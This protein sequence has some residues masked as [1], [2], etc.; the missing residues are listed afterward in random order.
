MVR[1][2]AQDSINRVVF[3]LSGG[4]PMTLQVKLHDHLCITQTVEAVVQRPLIRAAGGHSEID[5]V[6]ALDRID[7]AVRKMSSMLSSMTSCALGI[8]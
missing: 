5:Q 7:A 4:I 6:I 1:G 3:L 2:L 8:S